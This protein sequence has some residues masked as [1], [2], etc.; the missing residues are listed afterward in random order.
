MTAFERPDRGARL[1]RE[2]RE[3]LGGEAQLTHA[4]YL[5]DILLESAGMRQR[6]SWT[7]PERWLPMAFATSGVIAPLRIPW[8]FLAVAALLVVLTLGGLLYSGAQRH[9]PAPFGR[10]ENGVVAYGAGGDIL[11]VDLATGARRAVVAGSTFDRTPRFSRD[12]TRIAFLREASDGLLLGVSGA[13]GHNQLVLTPDAF[14]DIDIDSV[15]WS[16]DGGSIAISA[17]P[18]ARASNGQQSVFL[19]DTAGGG[20]RELTLP[21]QYIEPYWRPPDG[22][23]LLFFGRD[24]LGNGLFLVSIDSGQVERLPMPDPGSALRPLGWTPDGR[25]LAYQIDEDPGGATTRIF[26]LETGAE[27]LLPVAQGHLSND[28]TRVVGPLDDGQLCVIPIDGGACDLIGDS[29]HLLDG[30]ST[31][32]VFWSPDDQQ[33]AAVS[34][35]LTVSPYLLDPESGRLS[36]A[37][38]VADGGASWQRR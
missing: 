11:T 10:A 38:W 5:D 31:S 16:P 13:D 29:R 12:G 32:G 24:P 23:Q 19:V 26:D 1:E 34:L 30:A 21:Y 4:D 2:L 36:L 14:A 25:R 33:I 6:P 37:P 9:L 17:T 27:T 7:F 15:V 20:V 28:G 3:F 18:L 8:R 35:D 22:R